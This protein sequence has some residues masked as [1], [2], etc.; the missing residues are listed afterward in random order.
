MSASSNK[1]C[2]VCLNNLSCNNNNMTGKTFQCGGHRSSG[3]CRKC[4][5]EIKK[6]HGA[7][8]KCPLCRAPVKTRSLNLPQVATE[9]RFVIQYII[10]LLYR[11]VRQ[12]GT[13]LNKLGFGNFYQKNKR[14]PLY[15]YLRMENLLMEYLNTMHLF[16]EAIQKITSASMNAASKANFVKQLGG[17]LTQMKFYVASLLEIDAGITH[18]ESL[19]NKKYNNSVVHRIMKN[20]YN[21]SQKNID[22][23]KRDFIK[24][25]RRLRSIQQIGATS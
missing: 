7:R 19:N 14:N 24:D 25:L 5:N 9:I 10:H 3:L 1:T 2:A 17:E 21:L 15:R 4:T 11:L 16:L 23:A 18:L 20:S 12:F 8:A 13:D 6:R 22:T